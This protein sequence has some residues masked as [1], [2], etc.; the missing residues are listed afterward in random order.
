MQYEWCG[1]T[2]QGPSGNSVSKLQA[3]SSSALV[4][5]SQS[6]DSESP[7]N[8]TVA[9][10]Y[11]GPLTNDLSQPNPIAN[12]P[13]IKTLYAKSLYPSLICLNVTDV[14]SAAVQP[15][16]AK[17]EVYLIQVTADTGATES[18]LYSIGTNYNAS[19]SN[20]T[21]VSRAIDSN[22]ND[23]VDTSTINGGGGYFAFNITSGQSTLGTSV[24]SLGTYTNKPSGLGLWSLGQPNTVTVSVRRLGSITLSG[25]SV[26]AN[27]ASPSDFSN[28]QLEKYGSGFLANKVVPEDEMSQMN[29]FN[30]PT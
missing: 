30:P 1:V 19:F 29:P 17:I 25:A 20:L 11:V 7:F 21:A 28:V 12:V 8:V 22:I 23:F 3:S 16:D 24:G 10:A 14:S 9:Y 15:C 6:T 13:T 4:Q 18:Y 2:A 5:S 27:A 26:L